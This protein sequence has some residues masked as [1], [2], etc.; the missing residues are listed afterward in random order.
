MASAAKKTS[1]TPEQYLARERLAT[2]KSEYRHGQ[3]Y[4][5]SGASRPHCMIAANLSRH[6][7]NQVADRG[8]GVFIADMRVRIPATG[9]YNYPDLVV[10]CEEPRME[11]RVF[12]TLLNP[13]VLVEILSPSTEHLDRGVKLDEYRQIDTLRDYVL[14]AQDRVRVEHHRR[15]GD[16]WPLTILEGPGAVLRLPS[17]GAEVPLRDIYARVPMPGG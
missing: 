7:G 4:A 11:D 12:D 10:V 17:V 15:E 8:C 14:V 16:R 9:S 1:I 3:V 6:I 2:Y 5:M 13:A